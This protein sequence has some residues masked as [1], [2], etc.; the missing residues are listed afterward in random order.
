MNINADSIL[1][2]EEKEFLAK[3]AVNELESEGVVIESYDPESDNPFV[4]QVEEQRLKANTLTGKRI[5]ELYRIKLN[6]NFSDSCCES[7][8]SDD[9]AFIVNEEIEAYS[10]DDSL[11]IAYSLQ[12]DDSNDFD[13]ETSNRLMAEYR[14]A[15][16]DKELLDNPFE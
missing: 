12:A 11:D 10:S 4:E 13:R 8:Y 5:L 6:Q 16:E 2:E 14:K 1:N 7:Y 3:L 15:I 9:S